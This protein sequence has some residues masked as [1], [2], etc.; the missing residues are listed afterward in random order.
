[1]TTTHVDTPVDAPRQIQLDTVI[2]ILQDALG[3]ALASNGQPFGETNRE[4]AAVNKDLLSLSDRLMLA[5][6]L[7][8]NE[9]WSGRGGVSYE[10]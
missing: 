5:S 2:D 1:M 6:T 8:R 4:Q 7:V 10:L 3:E 9:Y